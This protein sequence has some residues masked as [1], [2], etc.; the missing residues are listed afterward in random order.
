MTRKQKGLKKSKKNTRKIMAVRDKRSEGKHR[1]R[2]KEC[3]LR[4]ME[5]EK[6]KEGSTKDLKKGKKKYY[7]LLYPFTHDN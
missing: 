5:T 2:G 7:T 4:E 6:E 3:G 1:K